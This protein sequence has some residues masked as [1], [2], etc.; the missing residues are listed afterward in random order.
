[1]IL[2]KDFYEEVTFSGDLLLYMHIFV[3]EYDIVWSKI[4]FWVH[5]ICWNYAKNYHFWRTIIVLIYWCLGI[6]I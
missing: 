2:I 4:N 1:L 6:C 5:I 3:F